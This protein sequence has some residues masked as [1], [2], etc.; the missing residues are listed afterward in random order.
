MLMLS[1][2]PKIRGGVNEILICLHFRV[3]S[4]DSSQA[5]SIIAVGELYSQRSVQLL[6]IP[7]SIVLHSP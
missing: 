5:V 4:S 2:H 7:T 1:A 6:I 3:F